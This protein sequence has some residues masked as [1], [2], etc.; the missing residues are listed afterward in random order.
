MRIYLAQILVVV[1][2]WGCSPTIHQT[3]KTEPARLGAETPFHAELKSLPPPQEKLVAAVYKFRDQTGQYKPTEYGS[4]WS[5]AVTQGATTILIRSLE[6]SGWFRPLERENLGNLSAERQIITNTL[7]AY[8]GKGQTALSPLLFA[9]IILEGGIISYETNVRTGGAGLRYFGAGAS[10]QY[11]E[12]RVS[13][14]LRAVSTKNGEILKTVYS[15]KSILSQ[16]IDFSVFR[17]VKF[18]RLLEAETGITYNEP[19]EMAV[20]EAIEKAVYGLVVEGIVDGLWNSSGNVA[21]IEQVAN[22]YLSEKKEN[23]EID[24]LGRRFDDRESMLSIGLVSGFAY[25]DVDIEGSNAGYTAGLNVNLRLSPVI[26]FNQEVNYGQLDSD[27]IGNNQFL[28]YTPSFRFDLLPNERVSP[29]LSI[30][31][32]VLTNKYMADDTAVKNTYSYGSGT[33]GFDYVL[34]KRVKI[35]VAIGNKY[36]ARDDLDGLVRG[37]YND[38]LWEGNIGVSYQIGSGWYKKTLLKRK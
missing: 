1:L 34:S 19:S 18:K 5:T 3:Q 6:E 25:S 36:F 15:T 14:Y 38:M 8:E 10:G 2:V 26:S 20:T 22:D 31:Y 35:N 37:S 7:A 28:S 11:R 30:G 33:F 32:G 17:Y 9:G 21:Y 29:Y 16:K 24:H 4:S 13:I 23:A 12:D 27:V